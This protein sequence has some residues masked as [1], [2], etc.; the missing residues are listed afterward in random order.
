MKYLL[1]LILLTACT[2]TAKQ[3]VAMSPVAMSPVVQVQVAPV[4]S[5]CASIRT[6]KALIVTDLETENTTK[7]VHDR[8]MSDLA[9]ADAACASGN[10]GGAAAQVRGVRA[11]YGYPA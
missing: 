2:E 3:P 6:F 5:G 8:I 7:S 11:K 1:P 10:E 9:G 4:Q